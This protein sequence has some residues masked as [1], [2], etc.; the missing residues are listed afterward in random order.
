MAQNGYFVDAGIRGGYYYSGGAP[1]DIKYIYNDRLYYYPF[2]YR[3][4]KFV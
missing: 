4:S 1:K 3:Y 2:W